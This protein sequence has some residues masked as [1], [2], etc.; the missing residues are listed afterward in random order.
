MP[1]FFNC[2]P[3]DSGPEGGN[4][5]FDF[6][7]LTEQGLLAEREINTVQP[8]ASARQTEY[9]EWREQK[10]SAAAAKLA[11]IIDGLCIIGQPVIA[12]GQYRI[13][14]AN[15]YLHGNYFNYEGE[16]SGRY[17]GC[18]AEALTVAGNH[19]P[20]YQFGHLMVIDDVRA[21]DPAPGA[22]GKATAFMP[23]KTTK[24]L[25]LPAQTKRRKLR[26]AKSSLT[27]DD[28]IVAATDALLAR[29]QER[30]DLQDIAEL[31]NEISPRCSGENE[32]LSYLDYLSRA[33]DLLDTRI[34]V[35]CKYTLV[36]Q[37]TRISL[38]PSAKSFSGTAQGFVLRPTITNKKDTGSFSVS[39][40]TSPHLVVELP[41]TYLEKVVHIPLDAITSLR[42]A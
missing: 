4:G 17:L 19:L 21:I 12:T 39:D 25:E 41:P 6:A 7:L 24:S 3:N 2:V 22:R 8:P 35:D 27:L 13:R 14:P 38:L 31:L 23:M 9:E 26:E 18:A 32:Y 10:V 36:P 16:L 5:Q 33:L 40:E 20:K 15:N 1:E 28:E 30:V 29:R 37:P 34:T 42:P 11:T